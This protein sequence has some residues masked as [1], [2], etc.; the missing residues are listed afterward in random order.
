MWFGWDE[1]GEDEASLMSTALVAVSNV[2]M[3]LVAC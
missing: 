2:S 3:R 1:F